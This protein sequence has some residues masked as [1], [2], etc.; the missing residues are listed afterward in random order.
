MSSSLRES[1]SSVRLSLRFPS[2]MN[3]VDVRGAPAS[4]HFF[5]YRVAD[6]GPHAALKEV[7]RLRVV[8]VHDVL[9][10]RFAH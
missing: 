2:D 8:H 3:M 5:S 9:G 10:P 6:D 1:F 7:D 4:A